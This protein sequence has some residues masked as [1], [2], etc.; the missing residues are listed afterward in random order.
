MSFIC[1][2]QNGLY[3]RFSTI[4]DGITHYNMTEEEYVELCA[5]KARDE[6]RKVLKH[7]LHPFSNV[8]DSFVPNSREDVEEMKG[9]EQERRSE[10]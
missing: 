7:Y 4:M 2:Q 1:K 3:C 5:E 6:A 8:K 9:E 10:R